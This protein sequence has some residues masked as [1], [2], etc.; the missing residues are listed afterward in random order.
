[1]NVRSR[2]ATRVTSSRL[3]GRSAELAELEA[4]LA[5]AAAERPSLAFVAGDSG[6]G[7]TRLLAELEQRAREAGTLVLAGDSVALGG[8][9]ELPYLP[10]VAA[11]RPLARAG[12]PALTE[13]LREAIAPLLPGAGAAAPDPQPAAEEDRQARIFEG[14]LALLAALAEE[15]P[16]LLA[17]ED[18]HW[19]DRSTRAA[20]AF[21][22]RNLTDERVLVVSSYRPDE[23]DRRH[24]L[25]PLL[26]ELERDP[27]ARRIA[28]GPLSRDELSDQLAD[29]LG[30][31]PDAD[32]LERLWTRSGGNPLFGEEL[33]AAGRDGR[34][35]LPDTLRGALMLRVE[36]LSGTAQELLRLVAAGERVDHPL[37]EETSGL[38]PRA[39]RDALREAVDGHIL[40][41]QDDGAYRFRHALLREVVADDL[42]PGERSGLHLA[43]A[44]ALERRLGDGA[45]AQVAAAVAHHFA[46]ADDAPAAL[47]AAM[48]AA[49]AAEQVHA[50]GEAAALLERALELWDRVPDA[51]ERAGADRV[52]VLARAADAAAALG[53]PG[54]QLALLEAAFAGLGPQP[55][56]R[57]A[58]PIL[59][60]TARAQRH[61]NRAKASIATLERALAL[62]EASGDDDPPGRA[63]LLAGLARARLLVA[64]SGEAVRVAREAL[65]VAA[66]EN[67]PPVEAHARNTLGCALAT[68][69]AIDEGAA[70]LRA[71]IRIGREHDDLSDLAQAYNNYADMLHVHGRSDEA[72]AV[73][74][75]GREAVAGRRPIAVLWLDM[76]IAEIAFD[77][78]E[79]ELAETTLPTPQRWTG[80]QSRLGIL[81]RRA[82][83]AAGRGDDAAAA[84]LLRELEPLG[85]ES[86]EPQ[87]LAQ[88]GTAR[89]RAAAP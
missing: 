74:V 55:D 12:D 63:V 35:A 27:R 44:Q 53:D 64:Q 60:A 43:L 47:T 70:E 30:A 15:R 81:L 87:V 23:L 8:D 40:V 54:R 2:V 83:L 3:I 71:A 14:L 77:V 86:S 7:K 36:R 9:S 13:P 11:L 73:A 16:V 42:L 65:Q 50:H 18:L 1:M 52:T 62:V 80:T 84:A 67:L 32:L 29:I 25:R 19:A 89:G 39:L 10:L 61:L 79:W 41:A 24:P 5:D 58:A 57:R 48:R 28:L 45:D 33:L 56:P 21:L 69:G 34:G 51:A 78:G 66:A 22:S 49:T 4:A 46:A 88:L 68:T 6:V 26:A 72:R 38:E 31:A 76:A 75:E 82:L 20:L 85:M 59:E 37:L 17:I